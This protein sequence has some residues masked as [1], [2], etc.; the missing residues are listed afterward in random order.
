MGGMWRAALAGVTGALALAP[1]SASG[2]AFEH[3]PI[4]APVPG[5]RAL[6]KEGVGACARLVAKTGFLRIGSDRQDLTH[7]VV[8]QFGFLE[9]LFLPPDD[10]T[11][12]MQTTAEQVPGGMFGVPLGPS[13]DVSVRVLP[14]GPVR[15]SL[16]EPTTLP[17]KFRVANDYLGPDCF[18]GSDRDPVVLHLRP[19]VSKAGF[20]QRGAG[21]RITGLVATDGRFSV[22]RSSGCRGGGLVDAKLGLPSPAGANAVR[23]DIDADVA[24][25]SRVARAAAK[26][27][28]RS[29]P[30]RP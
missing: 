25:A 30:R 23:L 16:F 9:D 12:W 6:G 27:R 26:K 20:A 13:T 19:D 24:S 3:C 4:G 15:F 18:I 29:A 8:E 21:M 28:R 5:H 2:G 11:P 14:A 10:G 1:A 17:L 7:P 22:P